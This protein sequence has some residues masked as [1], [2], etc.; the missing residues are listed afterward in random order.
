METEKENIVFKL[1][2]A[3]S[4]AAR[5]FIAEHNHKEE[6]RKEGK[7]GFT[8]LGQQF[9]YE[10]TPGGLGLAVSIKCNKCGATKDITDI[11]SW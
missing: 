6:F 4:K 7:L 2:D 11:D 8:A 10:I 5:E 1:N 3:E 9:T